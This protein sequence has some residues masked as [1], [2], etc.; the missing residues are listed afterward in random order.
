MANMTQDAKRYRFQVPAADESVQ[1][2]LASQINISSSLRLLIREDIQKNGF[3]DV[4]CRAVEQGPKRGRP[5]NAE[6][7]RRAEEYA[8]ADGMEQNI[9]ESSSV[10]APE[11]VIAEQV[12]TVVQKDIIVEKPVVEE[13][14]AVNMPSQSVEQQQPVQTQRMLDSVPKTVITPDLSMLQDILG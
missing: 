2:W 4:T 8:M 7:A 1:A 10:I 6:I 11:R 14:H 5:T 12:Q 3:S 9:A 13:Y